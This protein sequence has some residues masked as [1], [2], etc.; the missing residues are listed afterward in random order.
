MENFQRLTVFNLLYNH[1]TIKPFVT[2][3]LSFIKKECRILNEYFIS[4]SIEDFT[5][6]L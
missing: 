3:N 1:F 5:C 6:E 4:R 2:A